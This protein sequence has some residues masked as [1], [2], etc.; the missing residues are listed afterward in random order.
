MGK[1]VLHYLIYYYSNFHLYDEF[2]NKLVF[3]S[4]EK[5][6]KIHRYFHDVLL[7]KSLEFVNYLNSMFL[8]LF[9]STQFLSGDSLS[10]TFPITNYTTKFLLCQGYKECHT[11]NAPASVRF[12]RP[13]HYRS[14]ANGIRR[15]R[16]DSNPRWC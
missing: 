11:G 5:D 7:D 14:Y 4:K 9:V 2:T 13:A 10:L 16:R 6:G 12:R 1:Q 3:S 15:S 8:L